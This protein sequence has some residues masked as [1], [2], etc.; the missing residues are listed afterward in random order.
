M[1]FQTI[2]IVPSHLLL[3]HNNS[4]QSE[5]SCCFTLSP[6]MIVPAQI[7]LHLVLKLPVVTLYLLKTILHLKR[8]GM[9]LLKNCK[10]RIKVNKI[11]IMNKILGSLFS[12]FFLLG[13]GKTQNLNC[14]SFSVYGSRVGRNATTTKKKVNWNLFIY[15]ID[16]QKSNNELCKEMKL[17]YIVHFKSD[18]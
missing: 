18:H 7:A 2:I 4:T 11:Q 5:A 16:L 17:I 1:K 9:L 10:P 13:I 14:R 6:Y 3:Q 8:A 12:D 15:V